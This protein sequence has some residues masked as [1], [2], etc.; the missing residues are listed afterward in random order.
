MK[1]TMKKHGMLTGVFVLAVAFLMATAMPVGAS[2]VYTD[3]GAGVYLDNHGFYIDFDGD[4]ISDYEITHSNSSYNNPP[5]LMNEAKVFNLNNNYYTYAGEI[6]GYPFVEA[7]SAG[8]EIGPS[9]NWNNFFYPDSEFSYDDGTVLDGLWQYM[10]DY[11]AYAGFYFYSSISEDWHYGWAYQK[12]DNENESTITLYGYAYETDPN[13]SIIAGDTG[14]P[15]PVPAAV[16][17]L[18]SGL[19]GLAGIR[20]KHNN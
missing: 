13:I 14:A 20:R 19:L 5:Q 2:V 1:Q 3:L 6:G 17:L 10:P 15:V 12:I 16:W 7:H 11:T 18:G 4:D 9:Q 8:E